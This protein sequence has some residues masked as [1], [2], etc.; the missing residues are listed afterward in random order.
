MKNFDDPSRR[1]V[2]T[3]AA[4]LASTTALSGGAFAKAAMTNNPAPGYYRFKLGA[5]EAT[6]VSDGP[7]NFGPPTDGVYSGLSKEEMT[8]NLLD[9]FLPIETVKL[10]QN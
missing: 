2:L 3:G 9:H 6:V 7:L 5:F 8:K 10:D 1:R 4:A